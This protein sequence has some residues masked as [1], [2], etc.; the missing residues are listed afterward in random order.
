MDLFEKFFKSG[1]IEDYLAYV[2]EIKSG[3]NKTRR[4]NNKNS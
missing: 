2:K 3:N 1:K 4:G